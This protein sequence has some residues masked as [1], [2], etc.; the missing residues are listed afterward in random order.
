[1]LTPAQNRLRVL[2]ERLEEV[3]GRIAAAAAARGRNVD[4]VTLLA[5]SKGH[6]AAAIAG[7][8]RLG[9]EHF[10]EN[11]LQEA[12]PKLDA[13][14]GSELTWHFI[15]ALQANKTR[16]VAERFQWVHTVER[17]RI[18]QRLSAQ[19][20]FHAPPLNV[21]VQV[22]LGGETSKSGCE[23][24]E[25]PGLCAAIRDLPRLALRGLMALPP[26]TDDPAAQ[27]AAFRQLRELLES[28]RAACPAL[29]T[30]SMGM[31]GDLEAAIAE[32]ATIIRVGTALFGPRTATPDA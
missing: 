23:P 15:G 5:V 6:D 24:A 8:A 31:S 4:G 21:C 2:Q 12:L 25:V 14:A 3:R 26:P 18:A 7:L 17:L 22:R 30:L 11:Y 29:D 20:P 1:M 32:G 13:L 10:G 28:A 19:R 27:R 16:A 9:V